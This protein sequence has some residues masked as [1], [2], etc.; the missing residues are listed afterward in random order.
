MLSEQIAVPIWEKFI[1][2]TAMSGGT[3][4]TR[5]PIGKLRDDPEVFSLFENLMRE[6]EAVGRARAF[7]SRLMWSRN[8]SR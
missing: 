3:A 1:L 7:L 5:Q 4:I 6:T 8:A 2:L